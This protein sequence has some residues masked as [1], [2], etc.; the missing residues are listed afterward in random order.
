MRI[1]RPQWSAIMSLVVQ[2]TKRWEIHP[3]NYKGEDDPAVP[4]GAL[5]L[6]RIDKPRDTPLDSKE[7]EI[8]VFHLSK[9]GGIYRGYHSKESGE[10]KN[11]KRQIKGKKKTLNDS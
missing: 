6:Y 11:A 3:Y 8:V 9:S 5:R 2:R 10:F 4:F 1:T 7:E